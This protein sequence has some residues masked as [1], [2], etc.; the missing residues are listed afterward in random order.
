[1]LLGRVDSWNIYIYK[2]ESGRYSDATEREVAQ[3]TFEPVIVFKRVWAGGESVV[4]IVYEN[5]ALYFVYTDA[6]TQEETKELV[7]LRGN[8]YE[9]LLTEAESALK[10]HFQR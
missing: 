3:P 4:P 7:E 8:G 9:Q 6:S 5:K 1:M 10:K 2:F